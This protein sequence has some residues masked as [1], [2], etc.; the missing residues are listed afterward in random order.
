M[1]VIFAITSCFRESNIDLEPITDTEAD[2]FDQQLDFEKAMLGTYS[3]VM[4]LY[5]FGAPSGDPLHSFWLLPGDDLTSN[6][7]FVHEV[8]NTIQP[9]D[10]LINRYFRLT[11][12]LLNRVNTNLEKIAID[13]DLGESAF[14]N[15]QVRDYIKGENYFL[16]GLAFYN[17]WNYYG[18]APVIMRRIISSED[19]HSE[20]SDGMQLLDQAISDFTEAAAL[21]PQSWLENSRGRA[22][23]NSAYGY[24]GKALVF[25][26]NWTNDSN[27]FGQAVTA[28]D[29]VQDRSLVANYGDNFSAVAENN[30]ESIFEV[31][32]GHTS[33]PEDNVWLWN[34]DFSVVGSFSAY[35]GYFDGHWSLW[36]GTPYIATNKL[37]NAIDPDD[38]RLPYIVDPSTRRIQK[39]MLQNEYTQ[40]GVSTI[41]NPRLL[42]YADLLLLKAEAMNETGDQDGAIA[43]INQIRT[44]A[45][46]M[47]STGIPADHAA[48]ASQ[49]QV[50]Q[51]IMD[52]RFV[53][54]AAEEGHRW[55]D[56]RRWH[57]A[58]HL[59]LESF[60]FDSDI[61]SFGISM[62]KHLLWPIPNGEI[63][64]NPMVKQ[65]DGY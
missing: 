13:E 46:N 2:V 36:S 22:T 26:A 55:L 25:K 4:D 30:N 59:D 65:N 48:G 18:T 21:L 24:L 5:I 49:S 45:R 40:T 27:L 41:N 31:Q 19:I 32:A 9:G 58:G 52:E 15:L 64:L 35:Y 44:R 20:S 3:K 6:G 39:Y 14:D 7:S 8:F 42:R 47:G 23:K 61:G 60:D 43:L 33:S 63:D 38:P 1:L 16:R 57:K 29:N 10:E 54:F 28:I 11:Y 62:P 17:L 50:R 12:Q 37:V 56:L 34:D 53:E 51:W